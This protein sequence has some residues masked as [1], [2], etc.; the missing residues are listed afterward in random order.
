MS[1]IA[2]S[3]RVTAFDKKTITIKTVMGK[4]MLV[5]RSFVAQPKTGEEI[6]VTLTE[7]QFNE[8]KKLNAVK[9]LDTQ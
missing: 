5:P 8:V 1:D 7:E 4:K 9:S 3:G 6:S 2:V